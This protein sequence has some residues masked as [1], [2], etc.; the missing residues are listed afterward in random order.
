[1]TFDEWSTAQVVEAP[2]L[3]AENAGA[4]PP[5]APGSWQTQREESVQKRSGF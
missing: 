3:F 1:M 4:V 2:H 5:E